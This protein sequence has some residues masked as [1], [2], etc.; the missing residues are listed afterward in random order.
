MYQSILLQYNK[1]TR[2]WALNRSNAKDMLAPVLFAADT[3]S[4]IKEST[5]GTLNLKEESFLESDRMA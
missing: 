3:P 1:L 4:A 5:L 2:T